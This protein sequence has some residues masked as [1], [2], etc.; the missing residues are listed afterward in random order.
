MAGGSK[1]PRRVWLWV[2]LLGSP[3]VCCLGLM[4]LGFMAAKPPR[5]G[6]KPGVEPAG[7]CAFEC[8][9][10][11]L[12]LGTRDPLPLTVSLATSK[13]ASVWSAEARGGSFRL[14]GVPC[15]ESDDRF[16]IS[17]VTADGLGGKL[18]STLGGNITPLVAKGGT[19]FEHVPIDLG[20]GLQW[21]GRVVDAAG[22]ALAGVKVSPAYQ[23]YGRDGW[24][25]PGVF[26]VTGAD[27]RFA[28]AGVVKAKLQ[29]GPPKL[30]LSLDGNPWKDVEVKLPPDDETPVDVADLVLDKQP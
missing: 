25:P 1:T 21:K 28:L 16:S 10:S 15:D 7:T 24:A 20:R 4:S 3:L 22:A 11:G 9:L 5:D 8:E 19:R 12:P 27:G 17:V 23:T 2:L 6:S 30:G 29:P 18:H 13:R 14:A 26:A